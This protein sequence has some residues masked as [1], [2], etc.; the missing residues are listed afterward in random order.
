M[1]R[2]DLKK[3]EEFVAN[4]A[5]VSVLIIREMALRRT[6]EGKPYLDLVLGD[7]TGRISAKVWDHGEELAKILKVGIPVG[8]RG[9]CEEYMGLPQLIVHSIKPLSSK[10]LNEIGISWDQFFPTTEKDK[11]LMWQALLDAIDTMEDSWLKELTLRLYKENEEKIKTHPASLKFHHAYVGG[12]LEHVY[13]MLMIAEAAA[14][15]YP[16]SRDL[17][18]SGIILHD[19]GKLEELKGFPDNYYTDEGNLLGHTI[20]GFSMV[21]DKIR[22]ID[23]FPATT[24][25]KLEH[26]IVAHQGEYEYQAPKKPAFPEALLVHYIDEMDARMNIMKQICEEDFSEGIWTNNRNYFRIPIMKPEEEDE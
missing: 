24:A 9:Q 10:D 1:V 20:Q 7:K 22:E 26:I 11:E 15:I 2:N 21:R 6:R 4:S 14:T 16:V 19:I 12:F 3:V 23:G 5:I 25:R 8:V 17:L 13:T 18:I